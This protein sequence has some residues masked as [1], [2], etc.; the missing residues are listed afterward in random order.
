LNQNFLVFDGWYLFLSQV[1]EFP[2]IAIPKEKLVDT[3]AAGEP[4]SLITMLIYS[5]VSPF[6]AAR[7][8]F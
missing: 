3:N 5:A 1:T 4:P 7:I 8:R 6:V 2:V